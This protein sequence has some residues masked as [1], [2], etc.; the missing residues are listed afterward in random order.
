M[1]WDQ[2]PVVNNFLW[3]PPNKLKDLRLALRQVES[4]CVEIIIKLISLLIKQLQSRWGWMP[5]NWCLSKNKHTSCVTDKLR[6]LE[7]I[8]PLYFCPLQ[9]AQQHPWR[10]RPLAPRRWSCCRLWATC[11]LWLWR[12]LLSTPPHCMRVRSC[13]DTLNPITITHL[14]TGPEP[15]FTV[16]LS[17]NNETL[18]Q[19]TE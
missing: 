8:P 18:V 4:Y 1:I 6:W 7:L 9:L 11:L 2:Q 3:F 14:K 5:S 19:N 17:A 10:Q 15:V 12:A 13:R 16:M